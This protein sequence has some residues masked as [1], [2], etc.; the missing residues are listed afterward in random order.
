MHSV[1]D[2][3]TD[4]QT[5]NRLLAIADHTVYQYDRLKRTTQYY[6]PTSFCSTQNRSMLVHNIELSTTVVKV[7]RKVTNASFSQNKPLQCVPTALTHVE[8]PRLHDATER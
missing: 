2:R 1:T 4:R 3:Q 5:D 7:D 6:A 8:I